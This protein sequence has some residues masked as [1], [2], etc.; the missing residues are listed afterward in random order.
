ML[1]SQRYDLSLSVCVRVHPLLLSGNTGPIYPTPAICKPTIF[2]SSVHAP[3]FTMSPNTPP[4]PP[5]LLSTSKSLQVDS[6]PTPP[7]KGQIHV[8]LI[9]AKSLGVKSSLHSRPYVVV[10]FEQNEFISR[11]PI[12]ESD[13]EIK[14]TPTNIALSSRRSSSSSAISALNDIREADANASP[15]KKAKASGGSSGSNTPPATPS[16]PTRSSGLLGLFGRLNAHN[17]VWKHEVS[18]SVFLVIFFFFWMLP[19]PLAS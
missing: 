7:P 13:K 12:P 1:L 3:T 16:S 8:K 5:P 4:P 11:D 6:A 14:G 10:Q 18:L 17:P 2:L 19:N 9:Q 15:Q